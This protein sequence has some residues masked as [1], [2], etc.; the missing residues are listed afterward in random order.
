MSNVAT[1]LAE[2]ADEMSSEKLLVAARISPVSWAQRLGYLLDIVNQPRLANTLR[3]FVD[4]IRSV[5]DTWLGTPRREFNAGR[6]N[7][8]YRFASEDVPSLKMR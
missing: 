8:V 4:R 3:P 2:L 7:L 1:V 6:A 5:L